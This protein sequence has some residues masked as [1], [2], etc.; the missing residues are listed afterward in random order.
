M[1]GVRT[2]I[3]V[4]VAVVAGLLAPFPR[5]LLV[6]RPVMPADD[7][8]HFKY[9]SLGA[10]LDNGLPAAV[11]EI[12]PTVFTEYLPAGAAHDYTAFGFIQEPGHDLPIG[13]SRR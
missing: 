4:A 13:F 5:R 11:L 2:A 8:E 7:A 3:L 12:L 9:G 1:T 6:N 10:D